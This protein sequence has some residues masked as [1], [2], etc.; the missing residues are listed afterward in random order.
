[1]VAATD[2]PAA[3]AAAANQAVFVQGWVASFSCGLSVRLMNSIKARS[4]DIRMKKH[5]LFLFYYLVC[6]YDIV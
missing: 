1:M 6:I 4:K 5:F 2:A 3:P